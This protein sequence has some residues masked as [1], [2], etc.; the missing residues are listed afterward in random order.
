MSWVEIRKAVNSDLNVPLN[1][2]I[3]LNDYKTYGEK[4][5]VFQNKDILHELY[6]DFQLTAN[7]VS[8]N[9]TV[10]E[11]LIKE[12]NP[13]IGLFFGSMYNSSV[14]VDWSLMHSMYDIMCNVKFAEALTKNPLSET[15]FV[16]YL[17]L[18]LDSENIIDAYCSSKDILM[19]LYRNYK[20]ANVSS[21]LTSNYLLSAAQK[22]SFYTV[23]EVTTTYTA[24][25]ASYRHT[26][27]NG[28]ALVLG[29]SQSYSGGEARS[30]VDT[31]SGTV[32]ASLSSSF[33]NTGLEWRINNFAESAKCC[34]VYF[35]SEHSI[36]ATSYMAYLK[37]E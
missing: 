29:M 30:Y 17:P 37:I 33:G 15:F 10:L 27:Y 22:S 8:V 25:S 36:T 4:S 34:P 32:G 1:H 11:F 19:T 26:H 31:L 13:D 9:K 12:D 18:V 16:D 3:W 7:D 24:N 20:K 23:T 28:K 6:K 14:D 5:Y 35:T 21:F 2:L